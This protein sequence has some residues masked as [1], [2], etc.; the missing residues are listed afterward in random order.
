[1]APT[2]YA[3]LLGALAAMG[4]EVAIEIEGALVVATV[5]RDPRH[6]PSNSHVKA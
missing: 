1:M 3:Y 5:Q 6:D 4:A 2:L